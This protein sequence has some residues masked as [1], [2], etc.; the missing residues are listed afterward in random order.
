MSD[1]LKKY[2]T[3]IV[4]LVAAATVAFQIFTG[5]DVPEWVYSLLGAV[6]ITS[7]RITIKQVGSTT[8]WKTYMLAGALAI[9]AGLRAY[10]IA[11]P[12]EI[13]AAIATLAGVTLTNGVKKIDQ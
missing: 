12:V 13:D 5:L 6:G 7:A 2:H 1:F 10:G 11:I 3:Y 9:T 4:A 8:G